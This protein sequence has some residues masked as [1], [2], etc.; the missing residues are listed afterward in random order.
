MDQR[1]VSENIM[2]CNDQSAP[3]FSAA[4]HLV[5]YKTENGIRIKTFNKEI[6]ECN[7]KAQEN[8]NTFFLATSNGCHYLSI[9]YEKGAL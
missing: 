6:K 8:I 4:G 5:A 3:N 1:L 2:Q 7:V 9:R